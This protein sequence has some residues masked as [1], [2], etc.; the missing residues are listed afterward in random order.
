MNAF[1]KEVVEVL[2]NG[3]ATI[4]G[5]DP[6]TLSGDT[7]LD[8]DLHCASMHLVQLS[9]ILENEYEV[10]VPY[11]EMKRCKTFADVAAYV[12]KALS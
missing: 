6:S 4:L 5:V 2:K 8:A 11:M 12:D 10:E 1:M 9:T 3:A 7:Q